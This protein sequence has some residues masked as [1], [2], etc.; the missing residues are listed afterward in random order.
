MVKAL[1]TPEMITASTTKSLT[2]T[3]ASY[4]TSTTSTYICDVNKKTDH[5]LNSN[6]S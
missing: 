1:S 5:S 2:T 4:T 3:G 6:D